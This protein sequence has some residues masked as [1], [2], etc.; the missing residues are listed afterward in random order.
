MT[1]PDRFDTLSVG[2]SISALSIAVVA[3]APLLE[4][5]WLTLIGAHGRAALAR[6]RVAATMGAGGLAAGAGIG[7]V[8]AWWWQLTGRVLPDPVTSLWADRPALGY[9]GAFVVWDAASWVYHWVGHHLPF[10]WASHQ[11]HHSG[12]RYDLSLAWRQAWLP[13]HALMVFPVVALFGFDLGCVAVCAAISN[14]YQALMHISTPIRA[15]RWAGW[16]LITPGLHRR[17]HL[18]GGGP[19]NLGAVLSIWDRLAGT[20]DATPVEPGHGSYGI[21]GRDDR[22]GALQVQLAG[23]RHL[24][25]RRR[26]PTPT[27]A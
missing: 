6:H 12:E 3:V 1:L 5:L 9:L 16:V 4:G 24:A 14:V 15:P 20:L 11:V 19:V 27:P 25:G 21:A 8:Y 7:M 22:D 13:V 10:G 23:W 18:R 17:H 26:P 2:T